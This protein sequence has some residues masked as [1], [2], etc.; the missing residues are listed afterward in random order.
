MTHYWELNTSEII[1]YS[2]KSTPKKIKKTIQE[3]V[4]AQTNIYNTLSEEKWLTRKILHHD[5]FSTV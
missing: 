4:S 1:H 2:A 5:S 3:T